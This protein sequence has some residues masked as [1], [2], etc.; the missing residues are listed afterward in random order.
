M[1]NPPYVPDAEIPTLSPDIKNHEP[2]AALRGGPDG[3][4]LIRR[5]VK[6]APALLAPGGVLAL[7]VGAGQAERVAKGLN[8][9]GFSE[10][11][12]ERDY[13]SIERVVSGR[14]PE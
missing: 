3:L 12:Q 5:L 13:G 6:A 4:S 7:E 2:E 1:A 8:A 11:Q 9:Y 14:L 10:V